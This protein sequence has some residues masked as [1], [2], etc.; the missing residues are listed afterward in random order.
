MQAPGPMLRLGGYQE[1]TSVYI[2]ES[3]L[4]TLNIFFP[5]GLEIKVSNQG[6]CAFF[7]LKPLFLYLNEKECSVTLT[8]ILKKCVI[9]IWIRILINGSA[10]YF[11]AKFPFFNFLPNVMKTARY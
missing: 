6:T 10:A 8:Q 11:N 3:P 1:R 5:Q 9:P 2:T 7:W 4:F